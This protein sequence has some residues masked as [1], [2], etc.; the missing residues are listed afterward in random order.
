[1]ITYNI[2]NP[3]II[4]LTKYAISKPSKLYSQL[5]LAKKEN[6]ALLKEMRELQEIQG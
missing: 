1:M 5:F 2:N 6:I 4:Y 3:Q